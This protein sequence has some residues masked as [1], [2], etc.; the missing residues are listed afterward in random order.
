MQGGRLN[1][2]NFVWGCGDPGSG[3][4]AGGFGRMPRELTPQITRHYLL[5][6]PLTGKPFLNLC[7]FVCLLRGELSFSPSRG[8]Q[9]AVPLEV[10]MGL[11]S[12]VDRRGVFLATVNL[13]VEKHNTYRD[14][15]YLRP[16]AQGA[17]WGWGLLVQWVENRCWRDLGIPTLPLL[18]YCQFF[19]LK[20]YSIGV[21]WG[22]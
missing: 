18:D 11:R 1:C 9:L 2:R 22:Y 13:F 21:T 6:V 5:A 16:L 3:D 7:T 17:C 4:S 14:W 19:S 12:C 15:E 10:G 8:G 20:D